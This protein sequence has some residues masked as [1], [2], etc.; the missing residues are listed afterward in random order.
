MRRTVIVA[1]VLIL[2]AGA[3]A[4]YLYQRDQAA[5]AASLEILREATVTRD[6]IQATVN[7]TGAI[8]P[9]ALVSL[10]FGLSGT[11]YQVNVTRGQLVKTGDVL[12]TLNTAE[13]EL[14]VQ[15]AQDGLLIQQLT[16]QQ[17]QESQPSPATLAAAEADI[18]AAE[19]GKQIAEAN[20]AAAEASILQA[21]AQLAKIQEGPSAGAIAGAQAQLANAQLQQANAQTTYNQVTDCF[22]VG[23]NQVCPGLGAPE[24]QARA[25][26]ANANSA[27]EVAQLQLQE[28]QQGASAADIAAASAAVASSKAQRDAAQGNVA[29]AEANIARAQAAYDRLLEPPTEAEIAIL[30]AQV[31]SA[32]TNLA[33]AKLRLDQARIVAPIDGR[34]ANVLIHQGELA[35]PGAPA[36]SVVNEGAFHITVNV[37]EIDIDQ[38]AEGQQVAITLDALPDTPVQGTISEIAPTSTSDGGVVTYLVTINI[39]A[40]EGFSLRPGMSANASIVVQEIDDVL[41]VPNWAIRLDRETGDAYVNIKKGPNAVEEVKVVTGLRN[42]Q[43]SEITSGVAEGDVVALTNDREVFSFFGGN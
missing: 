26:L 42:E 15:Q 40:A 18:A 28:A 37:D 31:A 22:D 16:L 1:I 43:F 25:Q 4:F 13:L 41:V 32:E 2:F 12:A 3:G 30:Q 35:A 36:I 21:Q 8:E 9:E 20:L 10:N 14:A 11:I 38:I 39:I 6:K 5:Q 34:V 23:G 7:A 33:I 27:V 17:R 24:E 29:S 19:A